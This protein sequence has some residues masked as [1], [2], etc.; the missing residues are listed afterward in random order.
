M[1]KIEAKDGKIL[2]NNKPI[3]LAGALD[4]DFYPHTEYTIPSDEFL[5]DQMLKAKHLGLNLLRC[6]IKVP[7]PRY[8][9]MADRIGLLVWDEVPSWGILRRRRSA[10]SARRWTECWRGIT[11]TP[12]W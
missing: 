6:H 5:K 10:A 1:R 4:Q 3:F 11:T 12:H 2:L 7:D 9:E 8:L